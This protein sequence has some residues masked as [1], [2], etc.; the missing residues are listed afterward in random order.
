MPPNRFIFCDTWYVPVEL[1]TTTA[2]LDSLLAGAGVAGEKVLGRS[3][4][5]LDLALE[6]GLPGAREMWGDGEHRYVVRRRG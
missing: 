6:S 5:D 3:G 4:F 2:E 1:H